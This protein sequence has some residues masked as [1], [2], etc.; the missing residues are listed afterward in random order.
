MVRLGSFAITS[1]FALLVSGLAGC[2]ADEA[3]EVPG[4]CPLGD[5]I[6]GACAGVPQA[7]VCGGSEACVSGVA[8]SAVIDVNSDASLGAAASSA[9]AGACIALAP[10]SYGAVTLPGGV[11][12]L[13]RAAADVRVNGVALGA[14]SGAVLR[15][16]TVGAGG[17]RVDGATSATIESTR[18]E[19]S[20]GV[21]VDVAPGSSVTIIKSEI[22]N[23][24]YHGIKAADAT[25]VRVERT[26]IEGSQGPGVL[27]ACSVDCSCGDA[28]KLSVTS[29][30]LRENH[31]GGISVFGAVAKLADVD[32]L[33]TRRGDAWHYTEGGG[34][35]SASACS[36][37]SAVRTRVMG[38]EKYGVL[39]DSSSATL[40]SP[41]EEDG[42]S[43]T[44]N[45]MGVWVQNISK[46]AP[47]T[48]M[49]EN[50]VVDANEGVGFGVS[51]ESRGIIICRTAI[52][53]T[54][55]KALPVKGAIGSVQ[56]VG[57]GV[58]WIEGSEAT[59]TGVTLSGN[60]LASVMIDGEADG[61]L[62][63]LTLTGGDEQKGVVQQS[64]K[65]GKQPAV[66]GSTPALKTN[67]AELFQIPLAPISA[68]LGL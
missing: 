57:H 33:S 40:G 14:G 53:G 68:G 27:S 9:S 25:D 43:V 4:A 13:G 41:L 62:S 36:T 50:A 34:G 28:I 11:S 30:I 54:S 60:A 63:D 66:A 55:E 44:G 64:Y 67:S 61:S 31:I 45:V 29:S 65:G 1:T 12:L 24:T 38:S 35:L 3:P 7:A 46:V 10:G 18:V 5:E 37:L 15:G 56:K 59:F 49:I 22:K 21:G 32:I 20:A 2:G 26:I 42:I 17:V 58:A 16:V 48:V 6:G 39:V 47:Q 8:C 51:G 52:R 23:A 19:G